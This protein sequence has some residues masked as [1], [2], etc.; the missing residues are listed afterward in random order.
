MQCERNAGTVVNAA[1]AGRLAAS[2]GFRTTRLSDLFHRDAAAVA[3]VA[4]G[5]EEWVL[6]LVVADLAAA[7]H[8]VEVP[9]VHMVPLLHIAALAGLRGWREVV[10]RAGPSQWA[11]SIVRSPSSWPALAEGPLT[12]RLPEPLASAAG[13]AA[14]APAS[15]D[16]FKG[17]T[18]S[19][20][21]SPVARSW[22]PHPSSSV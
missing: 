21:H 6:A 19:P 8:V 12:G 22:Y 14:A 3:A 7:A 13:G 10:L 17:G 2:G 4:R 5:A 20:H 18:H 11:R 9:R 15:P 16:A 1:S